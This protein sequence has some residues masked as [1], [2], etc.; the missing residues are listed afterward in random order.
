MR[1]SCIQLSWALL[2]GLFL[3]IGNSFVVT[4]TPQTTQRRRIAQLSMAEKAA[5]NV[6]GEDLE[7]ML[8]EWDQPLVVDAYATW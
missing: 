1:L 2:F 4:T 8:T 7:K 6:S 3:S 5:P